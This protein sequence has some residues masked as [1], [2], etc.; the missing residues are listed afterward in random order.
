MSG[1]DVIALAIV[2]VAVVYAGRSLWRTLHGESSCGECGSSKKAAAPGQESRGLK[3]IPL[4]GVEQ[5]GRPAT[6]ETPARPA[7]H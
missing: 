7:P 2:A 1:Q 3:R 5:V 6:P 4:V